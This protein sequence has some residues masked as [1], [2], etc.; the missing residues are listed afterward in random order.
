MAINSDQPVLFLSG[1]RVPRASLVKYLGVFLS[2]RGS[3][4]REVAYRCAQAEQAFAKLKPIWQ[5][6]RIPLIE[7]WMIYRACVL[8]RLLYGVAV[9]WFRE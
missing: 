4:D 9:S 8:S 5:S 3:L 6:T 2:D 1:D 7:K